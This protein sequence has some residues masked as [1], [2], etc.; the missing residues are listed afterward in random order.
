MLKTLRLESVFCIRG[1]KSL[2]TN[3]DL[4]IKPGSILR[5]S[6]DNGSGKSSLLRI[7]C[8]LL[9]PQAGKV[10]WGDRLIHED[11]DQFHSELIYLGHIPALKADFTAIENLMSLALLSGQ[12]ITAEE[13]LS[14]LTAADLADQAHRAIRTL[15]QGQKQRIALARLRLPNPKPLWILDEPFNALDQQSNQLLQSLLLAHVRQNG[16]VAISSHQALS[17][18]DDP[19]VM[20]LVL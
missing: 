8:G 7:L 19:Q 15:S 1:G 12:S 4:E 3:L 6:G 18:D 20:R 17:I 9:P 2:F 11:R 13:A 16:M 10:V 14:A 5:I